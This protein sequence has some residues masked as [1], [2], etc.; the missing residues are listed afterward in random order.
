MS[1]SESASVGDPVYW[2]PYRPDIGSDPYP[3]F[4]RLRDEAPLY[5]NK[6]YDFYAVSRFSDVERCLADR[7]TFSSAR[8]DILE[9]IKAD[10]EVPKGMFIWED[11]PLH[12]A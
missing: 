6:E 8:S 12:S 11:P 10:I 2:D 7:E 9:F 3:V 5:Y 1:T 4:R